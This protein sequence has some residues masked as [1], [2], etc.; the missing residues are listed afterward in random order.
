MRPPSRTAVALYLASALVAAL[1]LLLAPLAARGADA[2]ADA[3]DDARDDASA[4]TAAPP[5]L[6]GLWEAR[7]SL[8][9][10]SGL[11]QLQ[12]RL[13]V[14]LI[15]TPEGGLMTL[16]A[17]QWHGS[18]HA[19]FAPAET[20]AAMTLLGDD[21]PLGADAAD[22]AL[23]ADDEGRIIARFT[24][25]DR[26]F[27]M[28]LRRS[29]AASAGRAAMPGTPT[30]LNGIEISQSVGEIAA[31]LLESHAPADREAPL[32]EESSMAGPMFR[33][34]S[35]PVRPGFKSSSEETYWLLVGRDA[36]LSGAGAQERPWA[37]TRRWN[38]PR[39]AEPLL[40]T[41]REALI[42]KYG[43]PSAILRGGD[44][45]AAPN[46]DRGMIW[47]Y[48]LDGAPL[49]E[50]EA[51]FCA[52]GIA[53]TR[54]DPRTVSMTEMR[55]RPVGTLPIHVARGCGITVLALYAPG[56]LTET[57]DG[58]AFAVI[59]P[60]WHTGT[61]W[62]SWLDEFAETYP[63]VVEAGAAKRQRKSIQ[64]KL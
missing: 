39:E 37:I 21:C 28:T 14:R 60:T 2:R 12:V 53:E 18:C 55:I 6:A 4:E 35:E 61:E 62:E 48:D 38:P 5:Q 64:P 45:H 46:A 27:E 40:G 43:P 56:E 51:R 57:A 22:M 30:D 26:A 31:T 34:T 13:D 17:P 24:L 52:Q 1:P 8:M 54:L 59:D 7:E 3:R 49:G 15:L 20:P 25:R 11:A 42:A 47:S 58:A 32:A 33:F 23:G 29:L 50:T 36:A 63:M 19:A 44:S 9:D 10:N 41:L 16:T